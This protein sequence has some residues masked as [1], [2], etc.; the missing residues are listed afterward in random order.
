MV[1]STFGERFKNLRKLK[2]YTQ[3]QLVQEFNKRYNYT[4]SKS[5][6]SQYEND[7]RIPEISVLIDIASYFQVS[8]DF[9]LCRDSFHNYVVEEEVA[10]YI[11]NKNKK[12]FELTEL[13]C[14]FDKIL[15]EYNEITF[16]GKPASKRTIE[17]IKSSIEIGIELTKKRHLS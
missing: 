7:K 11:T 2:S 12:V 15:S 14:E 10:K 17:F 6:I 8:I 13:S 5:A 1:L 9:L 4:L 3:D 16:E